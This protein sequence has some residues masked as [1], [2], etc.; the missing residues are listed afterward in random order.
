MSTHHAYIH[1]FV[2]HFCIENSAPYRLFGRVCF[3]YKIKA[4]K[5]FYCYISDSVYSHKH[6]RT[7]IIGPVKYS[8]AVTLDFKL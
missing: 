3:F 5:I 7:S 8:R 1:V 6:A 2:K 4:T